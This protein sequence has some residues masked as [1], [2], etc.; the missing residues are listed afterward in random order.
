MASEALALQNRLSKHALRPV[1]IRISCVRHERQPVGRLFKSGLAAFGRA[2]FVRGRGMSSHLPRWLRIVGRAHRLPACELATGAVALQSSHRV[3]YCEP[4]TRTILRR[5][6]DD[7]GKAD[8]RRA[9]G[10]A[11]IRNRGPALQRLA[12]PG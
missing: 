12:A 5:A 7:T 6:Q 10:P 4:K 9:R 2:I 3:R 11:P 8:G 1:R